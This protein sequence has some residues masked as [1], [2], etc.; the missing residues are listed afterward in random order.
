MPKVINNNFILGQS[1]SPW[2]LVATDWS[3]HF[4]QVW[5]IYRKLHIIFHFICLKTETCT[6]QANRVLGIQLTSAKENSSRILGV[7]L[8]SAK[9]DSWSSANICKRQTYVGQTY[10]TLGVQLIYAKD[11]TKHSKNKVV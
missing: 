11:S 6:R 9:V 2:P 1:S 8:T 10:R 7:Q 4:R 3:C 5:P